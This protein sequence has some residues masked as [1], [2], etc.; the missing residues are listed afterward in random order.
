MV[1]PALQSSVRYLAQKNREHVRDCLIQEFLCDPRIDQE[2]S[3]IKA[4]MD[5]MMQ[6][7][8]RAHN[9]PWQEV[10]NCFCPAVRYPIDCTFYPQREKHRYRSDHRERW[11]VFSSVSPPDKPPDSKRVWR[12]RTSKR[13]RGF[14]QFYG[15]GTIYLVAPEE[16]PAF[17]GI[18]DNCG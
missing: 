4:E 14:V 12:R 6:K 2:Y 13:C 11:K 18:C 3:E 1:I 17:Q 8:L 9:Y 15:T 5:A 7:S 10:Q 16:K